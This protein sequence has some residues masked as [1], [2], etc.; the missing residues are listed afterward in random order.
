[1]DRRF[2][3]IPRER[4]ADRIAS[5]LLRMISSGELAPG[6]RLPGERQLADM[7]GVSRVSVRAALQQL[8]AQGFVTAVQGGGTRITAAADQ[9]DSALARL[10]R[11]N[12]NNLH[13]L[14]EV[15]ANLEVWAARRAAE[16]ATPEQ[17]AEIER[18]FSIIMSPDRP[19]RAKA[20]D[21]LNFHLAIA[22]ASNSA[23]FMHLM[24][25]LG[26]ILEQM[27]AFHRYSL[28]ASP[29]DDRRFMEQHRAIWAAIQRGD[30]DAAEE[31]MREH[32]TTVLSRYEEE[33][34]EE[35]S[36]QAAPQPQAAARG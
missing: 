14:A 28:Y 21:D 19:S 18:C 36:Q 13:D 5:E 6:E 20:E 4:V 34:E 29:A 11:S 26:D 15:R 8:K 2:Q 32:L 31:A 16:R 7:M 24:S 30:G 3:E 22:K 27:F 33:K 9:L 25:I 35:E 1:M 12:R 17:L 23:V 10:V